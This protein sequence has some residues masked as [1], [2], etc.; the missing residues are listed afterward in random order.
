MTTQT[1][2]TAVNNVSYLGSPLNQPRRAQSA[3]YVRIARNRGLVD[4][5]FQE[6]DLVRQLIFIFGNNSSNDIVEFEDGYHLKTT[7]PASDTVKKMVRELSQLGWLHKQ[8]I[9]HSEKKGTVGKALKLG[10]S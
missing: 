5:K 3:D 8:I 7:I 2:L 1:N 10:V 4:E 9:K 6:S